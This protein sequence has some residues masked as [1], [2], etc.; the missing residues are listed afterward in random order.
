MDHLRLRERET[1]P[2][3]CRP[4]GTIRTDPEGSVPSA[5]DRAGTIDELE[6]WELFGA[7]WR[8]VH[9]SDE[10]SVTP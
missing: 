7:R 10:H 4:R 1:K 2:G 6:R 5:E 8:V 3:R 9:L